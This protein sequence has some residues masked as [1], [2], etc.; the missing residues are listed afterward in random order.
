MEITDVCNRKPKENV[1]GVDARM[2]YSKPH[3]QVVIISLEPGESLKPHM[4]PVDV[5]FY[6][7]EGMGMVLIGD[8]QQE[9]SKD[10]II[11][12]PAD[13]VHSWSNESDSLLRLMVAKTPNPIF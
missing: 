5:F 2:V 3:A 6:V 7:L 8:E 4:T 9:V 13:I 12:S 1:H 10:C 11:H